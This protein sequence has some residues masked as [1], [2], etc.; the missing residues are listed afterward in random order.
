[1]GRSFGVITLK[2]VGANSLVCIGVFMGSTARS[3]LAK[4]VLIWVP[5]AVFVTIGYEHIIAN[6]GLVP[7]AMMY[8]APIT[9][10]DYIVE[11][12]IPSGIGTC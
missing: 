1:M 5:V 2:A 12:I 8:G 4:I 9:V 6:M 7:M 10:N 11:S 3:A